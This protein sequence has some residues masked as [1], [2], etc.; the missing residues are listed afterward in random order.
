MPDEV[1]FTSSMH[2][3][4]SGE[5]VKREAGTAIGS[6]GSDR[7]SPAIMITTM[8]QKRLTIAAVALYAVTAFA[9]LLAQAHE[10]ARTANVDLRGAGELVAYGLVLL[11]LPFVVGCAIGRFWAP[12]LVLL[13]VACAVLASALEP[14]QR[15]EPGEVQ[16]APGLVALVMLLFH[17]PLLIVGV[18]AR[19]FVQWRITVRAQRSAR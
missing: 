2:D 8:T 4:T 15:P 12:G 16:A 11:V 13:L 14:L 9:Y 17:V 7:P 3:L 18:A 10:Y 5:A 19:K 6:R 1:G